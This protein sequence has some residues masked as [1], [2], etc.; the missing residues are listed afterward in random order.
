L[1]GGK[2]DD[3]QPVA[4][5]LERSVYKLALAGEQAAFT[6]EQMIQLLNAGNTARSVAEER[7]PREKEQ[8]REFPVA[9]QS[10]SPGACVWVLPR[11]E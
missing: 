5:S 8:G 6:L 3:Y 9:S 11:S 4:H 7:I 10:R 2:A 1:S